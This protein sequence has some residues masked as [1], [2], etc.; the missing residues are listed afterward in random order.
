[1]IAAGSASLFLAY[2]SASTNIAFATVET[3]MDCA[4]QPNKKR[5]IN[6]ALT[7]SICGNESIVLINGTNL[8]LNSSAKTHQ[9]RCLWLEVLNYGDWYKLEVQFSNDKILKAFVMS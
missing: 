1:M 7:Q 9:L 5:W 8:G 3:G 4:I 6:D 2:F